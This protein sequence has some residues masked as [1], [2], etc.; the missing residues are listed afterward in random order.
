MRLRVWAEAASY[1]RARYYDPPTGRFIAE[2]LLRHQAGINY[3]TYANG[4]VT[5]SVDPYG[6]KPGDRYATLDLAGID[7]ITDI[8]DQ[9]ICQDL[10]YGRYFYRNSDG[11]YS[12]S[13]PVTLGEGDIVR[14]KVPAGTTLQGLYHTHGA[15]NPY[16]WNEQFSDQDMDAADSAGSSGIPSYLGTPA[17]AVAEYIGN[18]NKPRHGQR[19]VLVFAQALHQKKCDCKRFAK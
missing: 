12:Y 16:Y 1:Y 15:Y 5:I 18:R 17:G 4:R 19:V 14:V 13:A 10:E 9:S 8:L 11:S 3:Y 7:A 6:L 2:D